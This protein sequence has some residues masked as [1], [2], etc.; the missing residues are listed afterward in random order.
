MT[1]RPAHISDLLWC[2]SIMIIKCRVEQCS[3]KLSTCA[4]KHVKV[5]LHSQDAPWA[6]VF[7][8]H[9]QIMYLQFLE[10]AGLKPG[11]SPQHSTH[12]PTRASRE[13]LAVWQSDFLF[14]PVPWYHAAGRLKCY[15]SHRYQVRCSLVRVSVTEITR[16]PQEERAGQSGLTLATASLLSLL[17]KLM[18]A[19]TPKKRKKKNH[20]KTCWYVSLQH[21][22]RVSMTS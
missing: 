6:P 13:A 2:S 22:R 7:Q 17:L 19:A 12:E 20:R 16:R 15:T 10:K 18:L 21:T 14:K 4:L 3:V 5:A 9:P 8:L 1:I 11:P